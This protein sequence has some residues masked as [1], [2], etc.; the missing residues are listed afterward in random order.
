MRL[1]ALFAFFLFSVGIAQSQPVSLND[2]S[3]FKNPPA[4]WSIVGDVVADLN[5]K[6]IMTST[7]GKG[8]LLCQ[9][10]I[11][12]YG[13]EYDLMTNATHG[14]A[15]IEVEFMMAKG[16]NSGI[17]LQGRYEIQLFDSWG[18]KQ[19]RTYDV[20]SIYERWDESKPEGQK[21]YEGYPARMNACRA[22]GLWQK[23]KIAFQAPR[24]DAN[25]KKIANAKV[26]K[27]E[28]NGVIVQENVELT[29][30]TRGGL[31]GEVAQGPLLI[32]GDHGCVAFRNMVL[33][34][35]SNQ[36]PMLKD[37]GYALYDGI[38]VAE[39]DYSKTKAVKEGITERLTYE[40]AGKPNGFLV[41]FTG[42]IT[43]PVAGEY[44]FQM[45]NHGG[46][47]ALRINNQTVAKWQ[48]WENNG[49]INL[50]AGDLPFEFV[51][52]K[53]TD[54][55][56]A[57]MGLTVESD[58][59]RAID[60]HA[61][62]SVNL[63]FPLNPILLKPT[64]EPRVHRSFFSIN[65]ESVSHGASVGEP[66]GIHYAVNLEKGAICRVWKGDFLDVTP[67]WHDRGNGMSIPQGSV[68]DLGNAPMLALLATEQGTWPASYGETDGYRFK[69]YDLDATGRPTFKY[70]LAG[71]KVTDQIRPDAENKYLTRQITLS[72]TVPPTL[73][74]RLA[75]GK[76]I[77]KVADNLY[78]I[79]KSYYIQA[80]GASVRNANGEQE[81]LLPAAAKMSYSL[82]W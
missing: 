33:K 20:G 68:L 44:R 38:I 11:G 48:W 39:P 26:L 36:V 77:V 54:W 59:A 74:C 23:L 32:Q 35:Y 31:E 40:L 45:I 42:K 8:V 30:P 50:P 71:V 13:R 73:R 41:R 18:V 49:K 7:P 21:G 67:M 10:P 47:S 27:V 12:K 76:S 2:M 34:P 62:G 5:Q 16:S 43:I 29:G 52:S 15:D 14:D 79:D 75:T 55:A 28:L 3:A 19:P 1:L 72:G 64:D 65:G 53:N 51:Y 37:L 70:D 78:S 17:Y 80:E 24:F 63:S 58:A 61:L 82:M 60:L 6:N 81:L 46:H 25:G 66:S 4:N 9:H 69:G 22:P 57:S 56:T